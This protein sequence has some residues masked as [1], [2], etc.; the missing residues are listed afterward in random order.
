MK[1]LATFAVAAAVALLTNYGRASLESTAGPDMSP[2]A[3][4]EAQKRSVDVQM[5]NVHF[6][7][8]PNLTL[9][10]RHLRGRMVSVKPDAIPN[11]DN[12]SSYDLEVDAAEVAMTASSLQW[13]MNQ[14][15]FRGP[16]APLRNIEVRFE[17]GKLA[18]KGVMRKGVNVPFSVVAEVSAAPDGT[19]R[20]H[21]SKRK[22][23]GVPA[24]RLL[25]FFGIELDDLI[26]PRDTYGLRVEDND[27]FVDP[28]RVLPPPRVRGRLT[29]VRIEG[30]RL[31]Q[32]FGSSQRSENLKP[33]APRANY[34][35]FHRGTL[36][37]GRLTMR[38]ADLQLIDADAS[39]AFDFFPSQYQRQ[40]VAGY[41]KNTPSGGLQTYM[42]DH[43][44][45][46]RNPRLDL[47]RSVR[48]PSN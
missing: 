32:V 18:Q 3:R 35:Y 4:A 47:T 42:P 16:D 9:D 25:D 15:V 36:S 46:T 21:A 34:L 1:R 22:A 26:S 19:M 40:L 7:L 43:D 30:S 11:F 13:L 48:P 38:P 10:V 27:I 6:R 24:G 37:F 45:V 44:D 12:P 41:S 8:D 39:D 2:R 28:G 31:V 23:A 33:P 20:I 17:N 14:Y 29:A 5:R